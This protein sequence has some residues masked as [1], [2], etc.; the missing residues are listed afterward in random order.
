MVQIVD[1]LEDALLAM[2]HGRRRDDCND[3]DVRLLFENAG[4]SA[5]DVAVDGACG[6]VFGFGVDVSEA[7]GV[8]VHRSVVSGYVLQPDRIVG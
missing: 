7:Q 5:G 2:I 8:A 6:R 1:A 4:D 3:G